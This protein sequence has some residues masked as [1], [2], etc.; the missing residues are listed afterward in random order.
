LGYQARVQVE[1]VE[2]VEEVEVEVEVEVGGWKTFV[3]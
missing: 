1:E 3:L 2:E